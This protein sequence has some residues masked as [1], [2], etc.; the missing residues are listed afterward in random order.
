MKTYGDLEV[1]AH[2]VLIAALYR[3]GW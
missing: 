3:G 2:A 1:E